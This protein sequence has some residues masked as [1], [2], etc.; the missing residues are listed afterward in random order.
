[1]QELAPEV[2]DVGNRRFGMWETGM[3]TYVARSASAMYTTYTI[4]GLFSLA[5]MG[6]VV[7][8]NHSLFFSS[9]VTRWQVG[10]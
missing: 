4:C 10:I 9:T 8:I 7:I 6:W 5:K 2:W 3:K 1:M